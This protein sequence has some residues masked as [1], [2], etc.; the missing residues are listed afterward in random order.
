MKGRTVDT[1]LNQV[2]EWHRQLGRDTRGGDFQWTR[3]NIGEFRLRQG[4]KDKENVRIWKI[5]EL[6]SSEELK[7]EGRRMNHCVRSY[8]KSCQ[9]GRSSIWT[10]EVEEKDNVRKVLTIHVLL[11]EKLIQQVRGKR[12]RCPTM[13]EKN[14]ISR[15]AKREELKIPEYM[16]FV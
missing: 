14:I 4:R 15:W 2:N 13:S 11:A 5:R 12:N 16:V 7:D 6:L 9:S 1:L 10:L 8:G 3:S